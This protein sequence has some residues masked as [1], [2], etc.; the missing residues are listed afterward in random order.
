M[1]VQEP[2]IQFLPQSG[3]GNQASCV[4]S[5]NTRDGEAWPESSRTHPLD[6]LTIQ[7]KE[8]EH[9]AH[10]LGLALS[11][12]HTGMGCEAQDQALAN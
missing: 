12:S 7:G 5:W 3:P 10:E 1:R 6:R 11:N 9:E 2:V 4:R 8:P